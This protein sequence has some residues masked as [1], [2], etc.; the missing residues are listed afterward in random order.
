M[1]FFG[2]VSGYK[3]NIQK[4]VVFLYTNN[5]QTEKEIRE[6]IPF[7]IASKI[8]KYLGRNWRRVTKDLFNENCK[9]LK[10]EI[11]EDT[12]RWKDLPCSWIARIN[13]VNI[14]MLPKVIYMFINSYQNS[15]DIFHK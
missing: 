6:T 9:P 11:K 8:T 10:R 2:K 7:T 15:N 12:K 5:E 1:N 13:I 3:L 14:A 4:S